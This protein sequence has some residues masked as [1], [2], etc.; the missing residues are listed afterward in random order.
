MG[1]PAIWEKQSA[2][3]LPIHIQ[4]VKNQLPTTSKLEKE[5]I[6]TTHHER[7]R[8]GVEHPRVLPILARNLVLGIQIRV[9]Q[10]SVLE[11]LGEEEGFLEIVETAAVGRVDVCDRAVAAADAGV[12][13]DCLEAGVGPLFVFASSVLMLLRRNE[14]KWKGSRLTSWYLRSPVAR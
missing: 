9:D 13:G 2:L 10:V 7:M 14:R 4:L 12:V 5:E 3:R 1:S 11:H 8:L 6:S